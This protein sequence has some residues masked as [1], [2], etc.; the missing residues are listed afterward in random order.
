MDRGAWRATVHGVTK[1]SDTTEPLNNCNKEL[2]RNGKKNKNKNPVPRAGLL[3]PGCQFGFLPGWAEPPRRSGPASNW[4]ACS[5]GSGK[6][7]QSPARRTAGPR[8]RRPLCRFCSSA[9]RPSH[10]KQRLS[11][12]QAGPGGSGSGMSVRSQPQVPFLRPHSLCWKSSQL[13]LG[14]WGSVISIFRFPTQNSL[15]EKTCPRGAHSPTSLSSGKKL[16]FCA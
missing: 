10:P 12:M 6:T 4:T 9:G 14:W 11:G 13:H 7:V 8:A 16:T 15:T 5:S 2:N 3:P 1:E